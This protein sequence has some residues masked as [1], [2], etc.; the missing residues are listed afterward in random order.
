[1]NFRKHKTESL[2]WEYFRQVLLQ[3]SS[4][5]ITYMHILTKNIYSFWLFVTLFVFQ[6]IQRPGSP[7]SDKLHL[8][9]S[10]RTSQH[11]AAVVFYLRQNLLQYLHIPNYADTNPDNQFV[12]NILLM[13]RF[14]YL[15]LTSIN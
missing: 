3:Y 10:G 6:F 5:L 2:M 14:C 11:L 9:V 8:T 4:Y 7:P 13:L 12:V 15:T 1:M